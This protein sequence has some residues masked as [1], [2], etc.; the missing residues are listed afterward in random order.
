MTL[1]SANTMS[2]NTNQLPDV[3]ALQELANQF[4]KALPEDAPKEISLNPYEHPR[5]SAFAKSITAQDEGR[6]S[7][8]EPLVFSSPVTGI[9]TPPSLPGVGASPSSIPYE[10]LPGSGFNPS[11]EYNSYNNNQSN[12]IG[13]SG[14][15][16]SNTQQSS[17]NNSPLG[18]QGVPVSVAGS[19]ASP[20]YAHQQENFSITE[21]VTSFSD[22]NIKHPSTSHNNQDLPY[23]N[24]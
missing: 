18:G 1:K 23:T 3:E 24:E 19:G 10:G 20:S 21:P 6:L 5:A 9:T 7:T 15:G 16:S 8:G 22:D 12:Q 13:Y 11:P 2:I 17:Q 4:F 14:V